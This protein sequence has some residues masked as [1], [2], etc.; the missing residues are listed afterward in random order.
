MSFFISVIIPVYNA[1]KYLEECLRSVVSSSAFNELEVV[2]VNDGSKDSPGEICDRFSKQYKN[3]KA[4]HIANGGVSNAR[5][6]GVDKSSGEY[7]TFCDADDYYV[8]D[9]LHEAVSVLKEHKTDMLFYDYYY[10]QQSVLKIDFPF[11]PEEKM[12]K[13]DDVFLFMLKDES[14]NSSCNKFFKKQVL[15]DNGLIFA[16]GQKHGEDRDFVIKFLSVCETA[17]YLPKAGYFYRLVK[18]S[19]VNQKRTDYFDNIFSEVTF[20]LDMCKRFK[21]PPYEAERYIKEKAV[22]QVVSSAFVASEGGIAAYMKSF[23]KLYKNEELMKILIEMRDVDFLN[24]TYGRILLFIVKHRPVIC[25]LNIKFLKLKE[26]LF[27]LI[28]QKG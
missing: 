13:M 8:N 20:K 21:V 11:A 7:I 4:I 22:K 17:Y 27:K 10:E 25:W 26:Q 28:Y 12:S 19:A 9:I 24:S 2:L 6:I 14:F 16:C 23:K 3:I 15:S 1:E 18:T 5:N